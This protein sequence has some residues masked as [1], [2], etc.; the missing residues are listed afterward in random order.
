[1]STSQ[2][3]VCKPPSDRDRKPQSDVWG[4]LLAAGTSSRFGERNKLLEEFDGKPVIRHAIKP[5]LD[6]SL[7]GIVVVIGHEKASVRGALSG[8]ELNICENEAYAAGQSTSV[9][10]GVSAVVDRGADAVLIAL[11]D[12]PFVTSDTV[13]SLIRTYESGSKTALAAAYDGRRGNPVLFDSRHFD[14]LIDIDGDTGGRRILLRAENSA[15]VETGDPGVR[16]DIDRSED[17]P[18]RNGLDNPR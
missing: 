18:S 16:R 11:G 12:M 14:A 10:C 9:Q 15:L 17:W 3:P 6:A 2:L 7:D 8:L 5:L 1:M 4:V 13:D